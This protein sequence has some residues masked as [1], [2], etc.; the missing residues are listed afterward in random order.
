VLLFA[1]GELDGHHHVGLHLRNETAS[2]TRHLPA[3]PLLRSHV[4]TI[5]DDEGGVFASLDG[6]LI[7]RAPA[8]HHL[9]A[10]VLEGFLGVLEALQHEGVV[11]E[12]GLGVVVGEAEDHEQA[13]VEV[14]RPLHGVLDG[15]VVLGALGGLHP[16][17]D[18]IA[19]SRFLF[20]QILYALFLYL[21]GRHGSSTSGILAW[22]EG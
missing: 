22:L 7:G 8:D 10:T 1:G 14:V 17:K 21:P 18:V 19:V 3:P 4:S 13:L 11:A 16:V 6:H 9:D 15:V 20:V 5:S 2:L 12:V